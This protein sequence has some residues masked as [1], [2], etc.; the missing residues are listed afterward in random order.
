MPLTYRIIPEKRLVHVIGTGV[1][2][3]SELMLH[4]NELAADQ[5]YQ[6]PMKK[7]VDYRKLQRLDLS[8]SEIMAFAGRKN[9]LKATFTS[10]QCAIVATKE[11][12]FGIA[13]MHDAQI[14]QQEIET[15]TLKEMSAALEWLKL[16][17]TER[18][19]DSL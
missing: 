19:L 13:R 11:I 10:E 12:N 5:S 15:C 6:P 18:E 2:R 4:I 3:F 17:L 16:D 8:V 1:V 14:D 9:A 7:L